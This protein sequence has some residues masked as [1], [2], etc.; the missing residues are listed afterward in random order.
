MSRN[1][2]EKLAMAMAV[3][4]VFFWFMETWYFGFNLRA[5]TP[6]EVAADTLALGVIIIAFFIRPTR[7]EYHAHHDHINTDL[8]QVADF[9]GGLSIK[10]KVNVEK[11]G[12]E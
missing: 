6:Q 12:G 10:N 4:G 3:S 1:K 9:T 2:R 11:K 7:M 8:V 5:M